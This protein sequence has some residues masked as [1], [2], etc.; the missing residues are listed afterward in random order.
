M[1][2][3]VV[4][5]IMISLLSIN[6]SISQNLTFV[7]KY[8]KEDGTSIQEDYKFSF[9]GMWLTKTDLNSNNSDVYPSNNDRSQMDSDGYYNM[10]YNALDYIHKN[11]L[12]FS[13]KYPNDTR[14][15]KIVLDKEGG[16]VLYVQEI[17]NK[18]NRII[19]KI[20][21][22]ELGKQTFKN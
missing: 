14:V 20:Y 7:T 8:T 16:N 13:E 22:T 2:K 17:R 5:L 18:Y 1:K 3:N 15:Y 9:D 12:S 21:L 10:V 4:I 11:P 19:Q 6:K